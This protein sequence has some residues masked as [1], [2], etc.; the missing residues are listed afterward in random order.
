MWYIVCSAARPVSVDHGEV[1]GRHRVG[2]LLYVTELLNG[3]V[4]MG[5]SRSDLLQEAHSIGDQLFHYVTK[6]S[7]SYD[8]ARL[9]LV[10][11]INELFIRLEHLQ[12][13][14]KA[15]KDKDGRRTKPS[16]S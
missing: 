12:D 15:G 8:Q 2:G 14:G 1:V 11:R 3:W 6:P 4:A 5:D 7:Y 13:K 9:D 10:I 16:T